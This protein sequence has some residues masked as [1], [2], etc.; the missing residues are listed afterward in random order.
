MYIESN[1]HYAFDPGFLLRESKRENGRIKNHTLANLTDRP[2]Y[3]TASFKLLLKG[4]MTHRR[5]EPRDTMPS[6]LQRHVFELL[7]A[8]F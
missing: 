3:L 5:I 1:S 2:D 8:H 7:G 6:E 4:E